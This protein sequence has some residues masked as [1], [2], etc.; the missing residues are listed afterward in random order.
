MTL[1]T[2]DE[3]ELEGTGELGVFVGGAYGHQL[4]SEKWWL[5]GSAQAGYTG[6]DEIMGLSL[7]EQ[8]ALGSLALEYRRTAGSSYILQGGIGSPWADEDL[9]GFKDPVYDVTLGG[10]WLLGSNTQ[11]DIAFTENVFAYDS[12]ADFSAHVSCATFF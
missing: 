4:W 6:Q 11:L 10:R 2:G 7:H 3:G 12:C 9:G 8:Y 5:H 1:P